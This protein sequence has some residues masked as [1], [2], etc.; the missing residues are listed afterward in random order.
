MRT[1]NATCVICAKP[2]YRRPSDLLRTRYVACIKHRAEAQRAAGVTESQQ[3]SL[4]LGRKK[5]TNH[6]VGYS[7]RVESKAKA[8]ASNKR[9]AAENPKAVAVRGAKL[10]GERHYRWSGGVSKINASIRRMTENRRWMDAVKARD[11]NCVRCGCIDDLESHH[12]RS[13]GDL[14]ED[15]G[16]TN[17]DDARTHAAALWDVNNG[18]TLCRR[19]HYAEHGR[20]ML[21]K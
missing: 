4:A 13:L 16:I 12:K 18:E 7:H 19:C 8:S 20:T 11:G 9:F 17:R 3:Q 21:C 14:I 1:P 15:L 6:R 10:R 2:I 5:G